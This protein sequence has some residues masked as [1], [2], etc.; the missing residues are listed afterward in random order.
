MSGGG[1]LS[2]TQ[3]DIDTDN[4]TEGSTNLFTTAARTR[5]HFTYGTG[6]THDGS[7]ALSVTQ[8]DIDTDNVTEGSTNLFTTAARTRGHVSASGDLNYNSSTGVFSI[9]CLLYTSPS[10]RDS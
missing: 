5:T 10:Q 3:A 1:Q 4:V 2:V 9:T 8:A 7:G 6:I